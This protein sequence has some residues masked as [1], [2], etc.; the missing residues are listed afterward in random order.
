VAA[1][2][3]DQTH[4]AYLRTVDEAVA[5]LRTVED[6]LRGSSPSSPCD[7]ASNGCGVS[8]GSMI[9]RR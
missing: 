4:A 1:A 9:S 8:G 6:D 2:P 7:R 3:L 5:R